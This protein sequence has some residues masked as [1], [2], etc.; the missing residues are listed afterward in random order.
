V[1]GNGFTDNLWG[2][3]ARTLVKSAERLKNSNWTQI[4]EHATVY[5][6][7][8]DHDHDEETKEDAGGAEAEAMS[9]HAQI[10]ID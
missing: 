3:R 7:G 8:A 9:L 6:Q 4:Q 2:K 1:S 10:D 5:L